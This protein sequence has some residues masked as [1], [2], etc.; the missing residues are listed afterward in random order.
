MVS[1]YGDIEGFHSAKNLDDLNVFSVTIF[2]RF[3]YTTYSEGR[4]KGWF[5]RNM[6]HS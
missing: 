1:I 4:E 2:M 3:I 6:N 5:Y